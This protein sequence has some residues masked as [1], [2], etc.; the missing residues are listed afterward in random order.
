MDASLQI[1]NSIYKAKPF[2]R[3]I[4]SEKSLNVKNIRSILIKKIS[5]SVKS[6]PIKRKSNPGLS[7]ND[8]KYLHM[9]NLTEKSNKNDEPSEDSKNIAYAEQ[10]Y[11]NLKSKLSNLAN[12]QSKSS[13]TLLIYLQTIKE[14]TEYLQPFHKLL[15]TVING[16]QSY[17]QQV[18]NESFLNKQV[19]EFE[20]KNKELLIIIE[21]M[22]KEKTLLVKKINK[23]SY[24]IE[25][26]AKE[27]ADLLENVEKLE[28]KKN[29]VMIT[30]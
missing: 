28:K 9:N 14:L 27:H 13:E 24:W 23:S 4:S 1:A 26:M 30:F 2:L 5:N 16:I 19:Q 7:K 20:K 15:T 18:L 29:L 8:Y 21:S 22:S 11:T 10:L 3:G 25:N 6:L 12:I 17:Y